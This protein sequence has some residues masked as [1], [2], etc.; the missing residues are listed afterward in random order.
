MCVNLKIF[1]RYRSLPNPVLPEI[2]W[3]DSKRD[4]EF[5]GL[6]RPCP[7]RDS[8]WRPSEYKHRVVL[9]EQTDR[10]MYV[11]EHAE[12]VK[13]VVLSYVARNV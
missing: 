8:D 9:L 12:Y 1:G 6:D 3:K 10:R 4:N 2:A 7:T 13:L 5:L 11:V